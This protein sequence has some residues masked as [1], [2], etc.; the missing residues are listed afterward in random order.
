MVALMLVAAIVAGEVGTTV[1]EAR[2]AV[3]CTVV[4]DARRGRDLNDRWRGRGDPTTADVRAARRALEGDCGHMPYFR[5]LGN[6]QDLETWRTRGWIDASDEIMWWRNGRHT[7]AGVVSDNECRD[8][9]LSRVLSS[10]GLWRSYERRRSLRGERGP[11][12]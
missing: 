11:V 9:D 8:D 2:M 12:R 5:F 10:Q 4:E 6:A 3:A 7:V 1:P